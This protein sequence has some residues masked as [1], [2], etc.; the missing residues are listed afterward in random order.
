MTKLAQLQYHLNK[1]F[2]ASINYLGK[3]ET[4][5]IFLILG[6]KE[7]TQTCNVGISTFDRVK[8]SLENSKRITILDIGKEFIAMYRVIMH[9]TT[10]SGIV[11]IRA[12]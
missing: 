7:V 8:R 9:I 5:R 2:S 6:N 10:V 11:S 4:W 1:Y 12:V 3:L